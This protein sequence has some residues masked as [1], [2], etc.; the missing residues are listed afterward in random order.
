MCHKPICYATTL[1]Q[2][3]KND[4]PLRADFKARYALLQTELASAAAGEAS[5]VARR[6]RVT[7]GPAV[8]ELGLTVR[9]EDAA[10]SLDPQA[11]NGL[12]AKACAAA[13]AEQHAVPQ[14]A[15]R[16][17]EPCA[18][19]CLNHFSLSQSS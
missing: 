12:L 1:F 18:H 3:L 2:V 7:A 10:R 4:I 15:K 8:E 14:L 17:A 13:A 9:A 11:P 19:I 16:Y 5:D 6:E